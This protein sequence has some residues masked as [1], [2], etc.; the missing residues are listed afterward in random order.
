MVGG[1]NGHWSPTGH[2]GTSSNPGYASVALSIDEAGEVIGT[3]V[4]ETEAPQYL[5]SANSGHVKSLA[6]LTGFPNASAD[7]RNNMWNGTHFLGTGM[8]K[9]GGPSVWEGVQSSRSSDPQQRWILPSG[10]WSGRRGHR[11]D[12]H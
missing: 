3:L 6:D 12:R 2:T 1:S 4:N 8:T 10:S 11:R 5:W 9:A 7:V